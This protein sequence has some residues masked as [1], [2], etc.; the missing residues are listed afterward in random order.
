M[1]EAL[2]GELASAGSTEIVLAAAE[3][4]AGKIKSGYDIKKLF[5]ETGEFFINYEPQAEQLFQDMEL[6]LSKENMIK[7]ANEIKRDSGYTLKSRLINLLISLMDRYDVSREQKTYYANSILYVILEQLPEVAPQQYDRYFQSEWREEQ[8]KA[9]LE[10]KQKIEEV[11]TEIT[12]Y[13]NKSISIESEDQLDIRIKKQTNNPRIG[14]EFFVIDDAKFKEAFRKQK[15][16]AIIRVRAKC[17]EEAIYCIINEL[18]RCNEKRAIFIVKS[19]EDWDELLKSPP[20]GNIYI[21]WFWAEE[22]CAIENNTNIFVYTDETPSFSQERIVLRPRTFQTISNALIR[23]G[24][25]INEANALVNETHG[26]YIPMKR[27]IFNG[28]YL[29][30][31]KW[32]NGLPEN[33]KKTALLIG[34]WTDS[35]GDQEIICSLSSIKYEEFI[36]YILPFTKG[37]DPFIHIVKCNGNRTFFLASVE[38]SWEYMDIEYDDNIWKLFNSLFL[39]VLNESEKLFV[40]TPEEKMIACFRGESLFWSSTLRNGMI[41]SLIMKA[42]YKT[43]CKFQN[44]LNELIEE[45]LKYIKTDEQWKY[46]SNFFVDLCE[47]APKSVIDKLFLEFDEPTGLWSLF[48]TQT[49]DFIWGTNYYINILFG[50][51]EFLVQ[52]EYAARGYEWLLRLDNRLYEYKSNSPKDSIG[53]VL[54]SWYNFSVFKTVDDKV[55]AAQKAL[56][57]DCNAWEH[58]FDALPLGHRSILGELHKPKYRSHVET[59]I[60]TIRERNQVVE[61][62]ILLL[63]E[64]ADFVPERWEKLLGIAYKLPEKLLDKIFSSVLYQMSQMSADEQLKLKNKIRKLIYEH[65]YFSSSSWA[66]KEEKIRQYEK[67]LDEIIID[68]PEY[69]YEYLFDSKRDIIL[70]NTVPYNRDGKRDINKKKEEEI[71]RFKIA[72]FKENALNLAILVEACSLDN[73]SNLGRYLAMYDGEKE[74]N[75]EIFKVL[76]SG[77][78]SKRMALDYCQSMSLKDRH[79]FEKVFGL[80]DEMVFADDFTV[81]LYQIQAL[82]TDEIPL[83]DSA[84]DNI[85]KLFWSEER[86]FTEKNFKWALKECKK[87]GTISTYVVLLYNVY[88]TCKLSNESLYNYLIDIQKMRYDNQIGDI[89]YYLLEL[90]KPLQDE[91]STVPEKVKKLI[92]IEINFGGILEWE[93]MCCFQNEIKRVPDIY[94]EMAAVVLKKDDLDKEEITE[95]KNKFIKAIYRLYDKAHFCP[96]EKNGVV[97]LNDLEK[98][99]KDLK[100]LLDKSHQ[101]SLFGF[102]LGRL[103]VYSPVGN[104]NYFPCEAVREIIE[105]YA[106]DSMISAYKA[107]L[108]NQRGIFTP[109]AGYEEREIAEKYKNTANYFKLRY[110]KTSE[111]F[112]D[113]YR[114]YIAEAEAER[115]RAENGY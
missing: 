14:I 64:K 37:E 63:I 15:G 42:F 109:S 46:I 57:L 77:Q 23:A 5:V 32:V 38:N 52:E 104:D 67:L 103:W 110:P 88:I 115:N 56:Q 97:N 83:I 101:T 26:L 33:I 105:K 107:A 100:T 16:N 34:Q 94:A 41:R 22:I 24:M 92:E 29:K 59:S 48:D 102:L 19:L 31:P 75:Q 2:L 62:Y 80:K 87:F 86:S 8:E 112:F 84:N 27:K 81:E 18:W 45:L 44:S 4:L 65:R 93:N 1:I 89:G 76:F 10:I 30:T 73:H 66:M 70:L 36:D 28:Q 12:L 39:D 11:N 58:I 82:N 3:H 111:I 9:L 114:K 54:C 51:E 108:F 25:E 72:E 90:L 60:V 7:L 85:K 50:I 69:E 53:K 99:V 74:F 78:K 98:W 20:V 13:K 6:V 43:D 21:P 40:Y 113:M 91:Y 95:S 68:I 35:E 71:L 79:I 61:Q 17:R 106:D 96:A 55:F 49:S 47:I